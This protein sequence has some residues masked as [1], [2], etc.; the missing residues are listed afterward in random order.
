[1]DRRFFEIY[2]ALTGEPIYD[3]QRISVASTFTASPWT[4]NG[5]IFVLSEQGDTYVIGPGASLRFSV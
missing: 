2:D 4:Y 5:R 3:R 1:M